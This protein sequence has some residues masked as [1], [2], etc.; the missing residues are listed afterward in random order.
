MAAV[1]PRATRPGVGGGS[2]V[3]LA[4]AAVE[5]RA[6]G[7]GGDASPVVSPRLGDAMAPVCWRRMMAA[8]VSTPPTSAS[9]PAASMPLLRAFERA[10]SPTDGSPAVRSVPARGRV[11]RLVRRVDA[12]RYRGGGHRWCRRG[13]GGQPAWGGM[14]AVM[15][16]AV[17][18]ALGE[19]QAVVTHGV[20]AAA[21]SG[22]TGTRGAPSA[23]MRLALTTDGQLLVRG[24]GLPASERARAADS[25]SV[26]ADAALVA[27]A[28]GDAQRHSS[29]CSWRAVAARRGRR[30]RWW[31]R[32]LQRFVVEQ[33][34][35]GQFVVEQLV[36]VHCADLL[37]GVD[38]A[39]G[40]G[41]AG[42]AALGCLR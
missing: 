14:P 36:V 24:A 3:T 26:Q 12:A 42:A 31:R 4:G 16:P 37:V 6:A 19:A 11:R 23:G 22:A 2:M 41:V 38:R 39:D 33:L 20:V 1:S 25:N 9:V 30:Q 40:R 28:R 34:G 5:R 18:E 21:T 10:F 35:V 7:V 32:L 13:G 15:T 27:A 29:A 17:L 8:G